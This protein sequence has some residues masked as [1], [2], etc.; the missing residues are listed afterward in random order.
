MS[1]V[2]FDQSLTEF[3]L[4]DADLGLLLRTGDETALT[5]LDLFSVGLN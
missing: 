2:H 1:Q 5:G 4:D 3:V